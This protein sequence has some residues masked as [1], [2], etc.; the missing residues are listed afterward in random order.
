MA[1]SGYSSDYYGEP[2]TRLREE[3]KN[4][5]LSIADVAL[6]CG[7][8]AT[9]LAMAERGHHCGPRVR[10]VLC[11]FYGLTEYELFGTVGPRPKKKLTVSLDY[12]TIN[13]LNKI[14]E[15][16][17][18][19]GEEVSDVLDEII[20]TYYSLKRYKRCPATCPCFTMPPDKP[21]EEMDDHPDLVEARQRAERRKELA[22]PYVLKD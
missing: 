9:A 2:L 16:Y 7:I 13:Q 19:E 8:S 14:L 3:R 11:K 4:A 6:R 22:S 20:T 21:I 18:G 5:D 15:L 1:L 12:E 10:K 17:G